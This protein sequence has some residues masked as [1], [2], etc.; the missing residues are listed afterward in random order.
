M[1]SGINPTTVN[2][3]L[4]QNCLADPIVQQRVSD[5]GGL[6]LTQAERDGTGGFT[7]AS[8]EF[9]V[10]REET[11]NSRTY[12]LVLTPRTGVKALDGLELSAD[13]YSIDIKN[14]IT[15]HTK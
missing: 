10:L 15:I 8:P 2:S 5:T 6:A 7:G 13:F 14:G 4:A 1:S 11:S 12:G 3:I 9:G